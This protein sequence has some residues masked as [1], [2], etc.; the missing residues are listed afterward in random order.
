MAT[1]WPMA[2]W[3]PEISHPV[4]KSYDLRKIIRSLI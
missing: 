2:T 4:L 1:W 3:Q